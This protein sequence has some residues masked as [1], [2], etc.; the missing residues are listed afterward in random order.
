MERLTQRTVL[1]TGAAAGIGRATAL[2]FA[3]QGALIIAV[4]LDESGLGALQTE[5][6]ACGASC[7]C[8]CLDVADWSAV[9]Q[10]GAVLEADQIAVEILINN[11]GVLAGGFLAETTLDTW[12]WLIGVNLWGPIHFLHRFLPAM[13]QRRAG[14]IVNV[15]SA[16]GIIGIPTI[17]AYAATKFAVVGL[18]QAL[19][20]EMTV[21]GIGVTAVCPGIINTNLARA[22]RTE[23]LDPT[24]VHRLVQRGSTPERVAGEIMHA[25][26]HNIGQIFPGALAELGH[27]T[28]RLAPSLVQTVTAR[29]AS[30]VY[31]KQI[32]DSKV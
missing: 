26:R 32:S 1:I 31:R 5:I 14:H 23:R 27:W 2:A 6:E 21:H 11:A 18:T 3:R 4:D 8:H 24:Q 9:D 30:Y 29:F 22:A 10:L 20:A 28:S 15:A 13:S 7:H 17:G 25:V 19:R 16:A 12:R